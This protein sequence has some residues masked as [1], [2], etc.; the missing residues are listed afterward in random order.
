MRNRV[1]RTIYIKATA[2]Q[3]ANWPSMI[4]K[5]DEERINNCAHIIMDHWTEP[6]FIS[7]KLDGQS[8]TF[9]SLKFSKRPWV[10]REFG[11]CSR[12][13][14]LKKKDASNYWKIAEKYDLKGKLQKF[15]TDVVVQGEILNTNV[16]SNKYKVTEP[17]LYV[18]NIIVNGTRIPLDHMITHCEKWNLLTVPVIQERFVPSEYFADLDK[19][20][21]DNMVEKRAIVVKR[22]LDFSTAKSVLYPAQTR[23][24]VVMRLHS[25]PSISLKVIS[26]KF[27][28]EHES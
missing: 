24:G 3:H 6:F 15:G 20:E 28:I 23:E 26:P 8:S 16:Q 1:F 11:V 9:F 5:T 10:K 7:E 18:F 12:N 21:W 14:W 22:L 17:L 4:Q 13:I 25:D 2:K 19:Q 27:Q